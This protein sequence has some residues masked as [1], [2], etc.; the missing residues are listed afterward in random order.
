MFGRR[1]K[2]QLKGGQG[3]DGGLSLC[4]FLINL[5]CFCAMWKQ[6]LFKNEVRETSLVVHWLRTLLEDFPGA[7]WI[8]IQ[9]PAQETQAWFLARED[10][11]CHG[12]AKP[13]HHM[14]AAATEARTPRA[15]CAA[16]REDAAKRNP[17][18]ST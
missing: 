6:Y 10:P 2:D 15:P 5:L 3:H 12:A 1:G 14:Q 4:M 8:G 7:K 17:C 16:T 9:L 11:T 18:L 13:V